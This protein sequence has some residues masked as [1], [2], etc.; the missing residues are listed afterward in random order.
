MNFQ[1]PAVVGASCIPRPCLSQTIEGSTVFMSCILKLLQMTAQV[2][3][4]SEL[5]LKRTHLKADQWKIHRLVA[6]LVKEVCET[7]ERATDL[8]QG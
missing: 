5:N 1:Y 4:N 2:L 3:I 6:S 7:E 8:Q